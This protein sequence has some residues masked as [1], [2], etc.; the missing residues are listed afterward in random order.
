MGTTFVH[1][2]FLNVLHVTFQNS[3]V[4]DYPFW[5]KASLFGFIIIVLIFFIIY[6]YLIFFVDFT[7]ETYRSLIYLPSEY[8]VNIS[9]LVLFNRNLILVAKKSFLYS[10]DESFEQDQKTKKLLD[11]VV[12]NT[13]LFTMIAVVA[14]IEITGS[15]LGSPWVNIN[16][17]PTDFNNLYWISTLLLFSIATCVYLKMGF[18]TKTYYKICKYP[19]S[20]WLNCV[21]KLLRME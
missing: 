15:L 14:L 6:N 11:V 4:Y 5:I 13:V 7:Y 9:L 16:I 19:H 3:P 17:D 21:G 18:T 20:C 1:L 12:R 8:I 2:L 10:D